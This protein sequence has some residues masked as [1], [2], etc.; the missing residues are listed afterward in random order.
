MVVIVL[1][2]MLCWTYL[3]KN[4]DL[5]QGHVGDLGNIVADEQGIVQLLLQDVLTRR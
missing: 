2:V 4:G 3:L 5:M 1:E